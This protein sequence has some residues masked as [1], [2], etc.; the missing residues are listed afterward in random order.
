MK[1]HLV[2]LLGLMPVC[3]FSQ[4][5]L[6]TPIATGKGGAATAITHDWQCLGI[7]P[8][9]LG[10]SDNYK[11]SLG[12]LNAG[13]SAQSQALDYK[14][15]YNAAVHPSEPF[16][17]P[18]KQ[19]LAQKFS[20][21]DGLNLY[22]NIN[23]LAASVYFP[24]LGGIA[25]NLRDRM[26]GHATLS[27]N[28]ADIIFNGANAIPYQ[29]TSIYH[30]PVGYVLNG[31]HASYYH[32]REL[33]IAYGRRLLGKEEGVQLFGG[34]GFKYLWGIADMDVKAEGNKVSG[35]ASFSNNYGFNPE[36]IKNYKP[37][38]TNYMFNTVGNGYAIDLGAGLKF[39][40]TLTF[41][42][43]L[44]DL[45]SINWKKN[46]VLVFDTTMPKL[47]SSQVGIS[48]WDQNSI[49]GFLYNSV[50]NA[51][52]F[53][54]GAPYSTSLPTRLR[55]GVGMKLGKR[56]LLGFDA[57]MPMNNA[58]GNLQTTF[59]AL[60]GEINLWGTA[61]L[62]TGISGNKNYGFAVPLGFTLGTLGITEFYVAT[63]DILSYIGLSPN[64]QL[65]FA[66]GVL[67]FNLKNPLVNEAK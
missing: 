35:H 29:D 13:F 44:T 42:A 40:N 54:G 57:V 58:N 26:N 27:K 60:G 14:T 59:L 30:Q 6:G 18:D 20:T 37:E 11:F 17:I 66:V 63:N 65:S 47:D 61:K 39:K 52:H 10:Y 51:V 31:T 64:P 33:N 24:K 28:A 46:N 2:Y 49:A 1:K 25:I 32:Y 4:I 21:P 48:N 12:L 5:D 45:G 19:K 38:N 3:V 41:A 9:N 36:F 67:R 8:A 43:A 56:I 53:S 62:S 55:L 34:A 50:T 23:W 16:T 15:I 22:G 7:N